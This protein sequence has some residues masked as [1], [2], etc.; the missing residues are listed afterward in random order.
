[1]IS[2]CKFWLFASVFISINLLEFFTISIT[3]PRNY[4]SYA[5]KNPG[6]MMCDYFGVNGERNGAESVFFEG[7]VKVS[8]SR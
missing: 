1:M 2:P 8:F 5:Q 3:H 6:R 7:G 4:K